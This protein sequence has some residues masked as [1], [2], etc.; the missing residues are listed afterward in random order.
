M[1][2]LEARAVQSELA[3]D[4]IGK[5]RIRGIG[6][7]EYLLAIAIFIAS[8]PVIAIAFIWRTVCLAGQM[9]PFGGL[10]AISLP[11]GVVFFKHC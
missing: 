2:Y 8:R 3:E 10:F 11:A 5:M 7:H 9:R 4:S 1:R 6:H